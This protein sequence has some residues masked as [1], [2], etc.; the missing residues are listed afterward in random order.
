M[1]RSSS[2]RRAHREP[3]LVTRVGWLRAAVLGANDGLLSVASLVVGV[4]AASNTRTAV[5]VAGLAA[6]VS[7]ALSMAV[8]EF[9]SV[10]AQLDTERAELA[11]ESRELSIQPDAERR[12]LATIYE[13]RGLPPDL[14]RQVTE[15]LMDQGA[16]EAH[17]RDELGIDPAHLA[18]PRQAAAASAASFVVGGT[19]PLLVAVALPDASRIVV[20][21]AVTLILLAL[22][23]VLGARLGGARR[24][25]AM[26]RLLI[27]G[28]LAFA[29]TIAVGTIT[30]A[31]VT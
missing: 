1:A 6:L 11:R 25:P 13:R 22:L 26:F 5:T 28:G 9:S 4:A 31:W 20:T 17:A 14:A 23:G 12:E 15:Y 3:H 18:D 29:V 2:V 16:L 7:G 27:G 21:V 24:A 10:S 30:G 19:L 8:G